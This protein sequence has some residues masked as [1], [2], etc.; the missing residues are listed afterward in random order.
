VLSKARGVDVGL[1]LGD[2]STRETI[3]FASSLWSGKR[4][5]AARASLA[6]PSDASVWCSGMSCRLRSWLGGVGEGL[7]ESKRGL[8]LRGGSEPVRWWPF[9]GEACKTS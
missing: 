9:L 8:L 2:S 3:A 4:T 5:D 7:A 6:K 1:L